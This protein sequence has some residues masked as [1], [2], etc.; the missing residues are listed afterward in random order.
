MTRDELIISH[1]KIAEQCARRCWNNGGRVLDLDDLTGE[2][3]LALVNEVATFDPAAH[4]GVPLASFL[5]PRI[6]YRLIDYVRDKES[7][8]G[9][10][11]RS[12]IKAGKAT[13]IKRIGLTVRSDSDDSEIDLPLSDSRPSPEQLLVSVADHA[14]LGHWLERQS[15]LHLTANERSVMRLS[16]R[17]V[18]RADILQQLSISESRVSQL[19]LS[20]VNKIKLCFFGKRKRRSP[21]WRMVGVVHRA[22]CEWCGSTFEYRSTLLLDGR[23]RYPRRCC[24]RTCIPSMAHEGRRKLPMS[25][26][27][28]R[29]LYEIKKLSTTQIA[30][31]FGC[32]T[33]KTVCRALAKHGIQLRAQ[34]R[35]S[36]GKCKECGEPAIRKKNGAAMSRLCRKHQRE[37]QADWARRVRAKDPEVGFRPLGRKHKPTPCVKCGI[38]CQGARAAQNHCEK[39]AIRQD[40]SIRGW[41]TRRRNRAIAT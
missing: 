23:P 14:R 6:S 7:L 39:N 9:R 16:L 17:D 32:A 35:T 19:F 41:E 25:E 22:E 21:Q 40:R 28:L 38:E 12:Q 26:K 20:A 8:G 36:D 31:L 4:P 2:A 13:P 10:Y 5:A 15:Y 1:Q 37:Y 29:D 30:N 18:S 11:L 3:M 33:H 24:S 27:R 34:G